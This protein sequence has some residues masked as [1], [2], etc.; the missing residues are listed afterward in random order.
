[1]DMLGLGM[2]VNLEEDITRKVDPIIRDLEKLKRSMKDTEGSMNDM[3]RT[4]GTGT[5][6]YMRSERIREMASAHKGLDQSLNR[7]SESLIRATYAQD[8]FNRSNDAFS[9]QHI[10][11]AMGEMTR[12]Q[13]QLAQFGF[14][15]SKMQEGMM[16]QKAYNAMKYSLREL[17][18]RA[19]LTEKALNQMMKSPNASQYAK[20]I[21]VARRSLEAYKNEAMSVREAQKKLAKDMG[22]GFSQVGGQPAMYKKAD[23]LKQNVG[24][25]LFSSMFQDVGA[26]AGNIGRYYDN[27][28]KKIIGV[29]Y[30]AMEARQKVAQLSG[31]LMMLGMGMSTT[32]TLGIGMAVAALGTFIA[33][34]QDANNRMQGRTLAPQTAMYQKGG[35]SDNMNSVWQEMGR[36][37]SKDDVAETMSYVKNTYSSQPKVVQGMTKSGLQFNKTWGVEAKGAI[38]TANDITEKYGVSYARALDMMAIGLQKT[39]GDLGKFNDK[40]KENANWLPK[41]ASGT[42]NVSSAYERMSKASNSGA[43]EAGTRS[44]KAM[45]MAVQN[46]YENS[47][48][49]GLF[50]G[51][52]NGLS[53]G[54]KS[55][56]GF[57]DSYPLIAKIGGGLIALGGGMLALA[58]PLA[59]VASFGLRYKDMLFGVQQALSI[60]FKK[61]GMAVLAPQAKTGALAVQGL[62]QAFANLPGL[63]MRTPMLLFGLARGLGMFALQ[64]AMANPMLAIGGVALLAYMNNWGGFK[65]SINGGI[66]TVKEAWK[67][68][69]MLGEVGQGFTLSKMGRDFNGF[70]RALKGVYTGAQLFKS[71]WDNLMSGNG[72]MILSAE[73][74]EMFKNLG[75]TDVALNVQ[76]AYNAVSD[77]FSGFKT[78][79]GE[80][81]DFVVGLAKD[82]FKPMEKQLDW[83]MDKLGLAGSYS[84]GN[85]FG[86]DW[87]KV[88]VVIGGV[89]ASLMAFKTMSWLATPFVKLFGSVRTGMGLVSRLATRLNGLRNRDVTVTVRERHIGGGGRGG[90]GGGGGAYGAPGSRTPRS[91]GGGGGRG[92]APIIIPGSMN[93]FTREGRGN[94]RTARNQ[95]FD[96]R[97]G[98]YMRYMDTFEGMGDKRSERVRNADPTTRRG[99][100]TIARAERSARRADR[101]DNWMG[102]GTQRQSQTGRTRTGQRLTRQQGNYATKREATRKVGGN[103]GAQGAK[104]GRA[105]DNAFNRATR[106]VGSGIGKSMSSVGTKMSSKGGTA[107]R[108]FVN[109]F[110]TALN[111]VGTRASRSA[112][113]IQT[114]RFATKGGTAGRGF[115]NRFGTALNGVGTRASRSATRIQASRFSTK[116]GQAGKGFVNRFGT[117]L[118]G[119]G[120]RASRSASRIQTGRFSTRGGLAG[121]GFVSRFGTA[122][123]RVGTMAS[124]SASRIQTSRFATRGGTAGKGFVSRFGTALNRVGTKATASASKIKTSAFSSAGRRTGTGFGNAFG[125]VS[126]SKM[127]ATKTLGGIAK[128]SG[129]MGMKVGGLLTK[130]LGGIVMKGLPLVFKIGLRAIPILGWALMAWDIISTI[131]TNWDAIVAGAKKA[132]NWIKKDGKQMAVDAYNYIKDKL[133]DAWTWVQDK[134]S[135]AWDAI[136]D[137]ASSMMDSIGQ[138]FTDLGS[139]IL[140]IITDAGTQAWDTF[141]ELASSGILGI[142]LKFAAMAIDLISQ[143][144]SAGTSVGSALKD[145]IIS[146][147]TDA[148][149]QAGSLIASIPGKIAGLGGKI[150]SGVRSLIPGK[151]KGGIVNSPTLAITGESGP[152][153]IIPLSGNMRGTAHNLLKH[154]GAVLGY[155]VEQNGN[156]PMISHSKSFHRE[157]HNQKSPLKMFARGGLIDRPTNA[158][159]GEDGAEVIIPM[160]G[161]HRD[162]ARQLIDEASSRVGGKGKG[163]GIETF[164]N[165]VTIQ[166]IEVHIHGQDAK[167]GDASA[168]AFLR[169]L[170][171]KLQS[172]RRKKGK[173]LSMEDM[174]LG[175]N[176]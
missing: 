147:V 67:N 98:D 63:L 42:D 158:V 71:V 27:M 80:V 47:G 48:A 124:R 51:L 54:F 162:R 103:W 24:N 89:V 163:Q 172:E 26:I 52:F 132:W 122:L 99:Q 152:E 133:G 15:M 170:R 100:R 140:Q 119:V 2:K 117:A 50:S 19:K 9:V 105:F 168:D 114:S 36:G 143:A 150:M 144:S 57:L 56:S 72:R 35:W 34:F 127:T 113:R 1:M 33:K 69:K 16:E 135:E 106:R 111:G 49:D 173:N 157:A 58:G 85:L 90:Y 93:P 108:G 151:S 74:Y 73:Q 153:A 8:K 167:N 60:G 102:T 95:K 70:E 138:Y 12:A 134:A 65:D 75:M 159:A 96:A 20:E 165:S 53:S 149:A 97:Y 110:G 91:Q 139:D 13:R 107:G 41:L 164:D 64:V 28:G 101:M 169:A 59:L 38:D 77:F 66:G 83:I 104:A 87:T 22:L 121:R 148:V 10:Q 84:E 62:V 120:T 92:G 126:R 141:L 137:K 109:R 68:V 156:K 79:F 45:G 175:I 130:G 3:Y 160:A 142:P 112:S 131:F 14:G 129:R 25:R 55:I 11:R 7:V 176:L 4:V 76:K 128:G 30:T 17:E 78:G 171:K 155:N 136:K 46:L 44:L 5:D 18:D 88:G 31:S 37:V 154:A 115:V 21:D 146:M 86:I 23:S 123:N 82:L 32:V 6:R 40:M 29:G 174:I 161:K 81:Y 116:G 94:R 166:K 43:V 39:D 125:K 145:G 61:G 118:N